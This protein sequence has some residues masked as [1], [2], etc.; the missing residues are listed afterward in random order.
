MVLA[1]WIVR[2]RWCWQ[3]EA[4]TDDDAD[5]GTDDDADGGTHNLNPSFLMI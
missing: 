3:D 1:V 4:D 2:I 5:G